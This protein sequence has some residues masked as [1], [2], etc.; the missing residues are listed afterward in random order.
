[1]KDLMQNPTTFVAIH[2]MMENCNKVNNLC[3]FFTLCS[4][5]KAITHTQKHSELFVMQVI[6]IL[7]DKS[8]HIV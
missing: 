2:Q 4:Q 7:E 5:E 6:F 3:I 8:S 1:M